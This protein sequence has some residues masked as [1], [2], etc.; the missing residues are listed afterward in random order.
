MSFIEKMREAA[1]QFEA[2][3]P[4][5]WRKVIEPFVSGV[6]AVSTAGLLDLVDAR[7]TTK[8]ARRLAGIMRELKF[9]A[10]QSRRLM[11]GGHLSTVARGWS[12][13][14]R[15]SSA[16]KKVKPQQGTPSPRSNFATQGDDDVF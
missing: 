1:K 13:T 9:V 8:N 16:S 10:M 11:P 7:H 14:V 4:D 6:D 2:P 5:P 15:L 3:P 12:R